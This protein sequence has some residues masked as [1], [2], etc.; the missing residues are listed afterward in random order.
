MTDDKTKLQQLI[1]EAIQGD[2]W[3]IE[4]KPFV[5]PPSPA[6][7]K[8][9]RP[10]YNYKKPPQRYYPPP[11]LTTQLQQQPSR[12]ISQETS[13][14][15]EFHDMASKRVFS[16]AEPTR[17][18]YFEQDNDEEL[19]NQYGRLEEESTTTS[20]ST[21]DYAATTT[22]DLP[23]QYDVQDNDMQLAIEASF[24]NHFEQHEK[25]ED[26]YA[27]LS[28]EEREAMQLAISETQ[29]E[30]FRTEWLNELN[31]Q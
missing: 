18:N 26:F 25:E 27:D 31:D 29:L 20:C 7:Y 8:T 9:Q 28:P 4:S 1:D 6:S 30:Q 12:E 16:V 11:S 10:L 15:V 5:P 22:K 17:V 2:E 24:L 23:V 13:H 14:P 19:L 21:R 3:A